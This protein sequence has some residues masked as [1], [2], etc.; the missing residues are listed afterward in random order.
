[1]TSLAAGDTVTQPVNGF[2]E[3]LQNYVSEQT[4]VYADKARFTYIAGAGG[5]GFNW[6][7]NDTEI[8]KGFNGLLDDVYG[9]LKGQYPNTSP[10]TNTEKWYYTFPR[11]SMVT[12]RLRSTGISPQITASKTN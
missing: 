10:S 6:G 8:A 1:M 7:Y 2:D 5:N 12:P 11:Q 9:F 4:P 3:P